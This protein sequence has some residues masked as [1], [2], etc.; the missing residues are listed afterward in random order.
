MTLE[1][2]G[3]N[4]LQ[5]GGDHY[6]RMA[7]QPWDFITANG[8]DFL[9]GSAIAYLCRW[10][11]KGGLADLRKAIHCIQKLIEV[12]HGFTVHSGGNTERSPS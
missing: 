6:K 12:N 11:T 5:I 2:E 3:V 10:K 7:I 1:S 8:I 9:E 4:G